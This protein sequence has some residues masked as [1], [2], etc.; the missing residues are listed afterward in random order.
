MNEQARES[1]SE[2]LNEWI[3]EYTN[4][5]LHKQI[6]LFYVAW[7]LNFGQQLLACKMGVTRL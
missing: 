7:E 5:W 4:Q 2:L 3:N 1:M 6:F